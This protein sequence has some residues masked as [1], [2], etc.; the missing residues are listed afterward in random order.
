MLCSNPP[1]DQSAHSLATPA[2]HSGTFADSILPDQPDWSSWGITNEIFIAQDYTQSVPFE[3]SD[4]ITA[5]S[6]PTGPPDSIFDGLQVPSW[7]VGHGSAASTP[8]VLFSHPIVYHDSTKKRKR[9]PSRECD[10]QPRPIT[11]TDSFSSVESS[12]GTRSNNNLITKGLIRIYNDVLENNLSCWLA[13]YT[14]PYKMERHPFRQDAVVT[15]GTVRQCGVSEPI[16]QNRILHRVIQL[17]RYAQS[18]NMICLTRYENAAVSRAL[19]LAIMAYAA[20]WAQG[21]RRHAKHSWASSDF[22]EDLAADIADEFADSFEQTL[23]QTVWE[24]ANRALKEISH[25]ESY[26]AVLAQ[27]IF[28]LTNKPWRSKDYD[29]LEDISASE[30]FSGQVYGDGA[31]IIAQLKQLISQEGP[32]LVMESAARK[33]HALKRRFEGL[34]TGYNDV[35]SSANASAS[36][37]AISS[38]NR[39]T[40]GLLYWLAVMFDTVSS[41]MEGRPNAL[42][43]EDCQNDE[44]RVRQ[45]NVQRQDH[46][47]SISYHW[48]LDYFA[49]DAL[50]PKRLRWPC[51]YEVAAD[52][53]IRSAP[54]KVLL[55]RHISYLQSALSRQAPRGHIEDLLQA[56]T[57]TY[58]YWNTTFGPFFKDLVQHYDSVPPRIKGWFV[59]ITIP[60]LLGS[61]MLADLVDFINKKGLGQEEG[62]L[63]R[64]GHV[65][66][67]TIRK[68]SAVELSEMARVT[69]PVTAK[70]EQPLQQL[71]DLHF[72]VNEGATLTEPW[73]MILIRAFTKAAVFHLDSALKASKLEEWFALG[74]QDQEF[75]DSSRHCQNCIEALWFLGRKAQLARNLAQVLSRAFESVSRGSS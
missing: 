20:Q 12:L 70:G 47:S 27:L 75:M 40:I 26:R 13:E 72:A 8:P 55:F 65:S 61:L 4:G 38:D 28:G 71:P 74:H 10:S 54:V 45:Q 2:C 34:D 3:D 49:G 56:A 73:T 57:E 18:K 15:A 32:P 6:D 53:V 9:R 23:Q 1:N 52:A 41:S 36:V 17:D 21:K 48:K 35:S 11:P 68:A 46:P 14:C 60:W 58:C 63:S 30:P 25:V 16:W 43:D 50:E 5:W 19:N 44:I 42:C 66:A 22:T 59:C 33:M 67:S 29:T 62:Q 51:T 24:Q 69:K 37:M 64:F 7:G 31:S 39:R